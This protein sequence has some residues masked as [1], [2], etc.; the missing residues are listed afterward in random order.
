MDRF[1][2]IIVTI[3]LGCSFFVG[4]AQWDLKEEHNEKRLHRWLMMKQFFE[5]TDTYST[6]VKSEKPLI[7]L[8]VDGVS[9]FNY[10]TNQP[11]P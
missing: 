9:P 6:K 8:L 2:K 4:I 3:I 10:S 11:M 5:Q 1:E 7:G